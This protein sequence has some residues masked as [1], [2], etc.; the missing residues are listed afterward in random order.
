[1]AITRSPPSK[2]RPRAGKGGI[3]LPEIIVNHAERALIQSRVRSDQIGS[4]SALGARL[5]DSLNSWDVH[6]LVRMHAR[7]SSS[8]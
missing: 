7:I 5:R 2:L 4:V 1:V 8:R 3:C 6:A